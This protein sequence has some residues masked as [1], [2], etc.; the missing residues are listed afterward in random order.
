MSSFDVFSGS[1]L[2]LKWRWVCFEWKLIAIK[3]FDLKE[4]CCFYKYALPKNFWV[5]REEIAES[6]HKK[7]SAPIREVQQVLE[8][9]SQLRLMVICSLFDFRLAHL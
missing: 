2:P 5:D 4:T 9:F 8:S 6:V 3:M 1:C 7:W